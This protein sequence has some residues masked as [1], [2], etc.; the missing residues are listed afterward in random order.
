M[1]RNVI[2]KI[3]IF[4][5]FLFLVCCD[6]AVEQKT[7]CEL[8]GHNFVSGVCTV[9]SEK[10]PDYKEDEVIVP[11]EKT[12]CEK[13]GHNFVK[14]VCT[15]CSEKDPDYKEDE[16]I[17]PVET[18]H[19]IKNADGSY[20]GSL[21]ISKYGV[22]A[23]LNGAYNKIDSKYYA[24][25]DYYN[26]FSTNTRTLIPNVR[27]YQQ[28]MQDSSGIACA[29]MIMDYSQEDMSE[30]SELS[31]VNEYEKINKTTIYNNGT[32][33]E[34]LKKL[35]DEYGYI[36]K[37]SVYK[38]VSS[39][40]NDVVTDF[41]D[42]LKTEL[43]L[44]RFV[45]VRFQDNI[46]SGWRMIIGMDDMGTPLNALDNVIIFADPFDAG[47]HLQD[48]YSTMAA[49]RFYKWWQIL[50]ESGV[51][52]S[53]FDYLIV[54]PK[55]IPD[56]RVREETVFSTQVAPEK[57][58]WLNADG[59][60]GGSSNPTLYG[61]G[62]TANGA[63]DV[64]ST[65][66]YKLPDCYNWVSEG[67]L[68]MLTNFRAYQQTMA[69]SCG[70]CSTMTTML[71]MGVDPKD[72]GINS[73]SEFEEYLV[74]KYE[75]ITGKIIY[76]SGVGATGLHQLTGTGGSGETGFGFNPIKGYF[77][78]DKYVNENSK[79]FKTYNDFKDWAISYIDKKVPLP[80]SWRPQGGHW[81]VII[82]FDDMGTDYIYDD[83]LILGDSG[84]SWD[85]YRDGYNI[86][87]ATL[88]YR[89]W[90]NGSFTYNQQFNIFT[91]D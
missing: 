35:F 36:T 42:W 67:S 90:Y 27:S 86:L 84:D 65:I 51:V 30:I 89:Q 87:P 23:P 75:K 72:Y 3:L 55:V 81:E 54:A 1:K 15:V 64:I 61:N 7:Q 45:L 91:I 17:I 52:S 11:I 71:Y 69:S 22:G 83:V 85:N 40:R 37:L 8:I 77:S 79:E 47:D 29:L 60:Y 62:T 10:D 33:K 78:R 20:G 46:N 34:G 31:L 58:L 68:H 88:F 19:L 12:Q 73:V 28:T 41:C 25:N 38:E 48:G 4:V 80:I 32:T 63:D 76:N 24:N 56:M 13:I 53:T 59:T 82:G 74:K 49:G 43:V 57:H 9:C 26:M 6:N 66:Y 39:A 70:I 14:G 18:N 5:L 2:F 44:G 21:D 50:E 16:V